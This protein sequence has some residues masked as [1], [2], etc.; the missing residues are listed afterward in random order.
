MTS[1]TT[2]GARFAGAAVPGAAAVLATGTAREPSCDAHAAAKKRAEITRAARTR[3]EYH[4][5]PMKRL[6]FALA[7]LACNKTDAS[8][9]TAEAAAP[10]ATKSAAPAA[11]FTGTLTGDRVMG[12]KG[13]VHPFDPWPDAQAKLEA[14]VGK[15][16]LVKNDKY[17]WAASQG[18]DCFYMQVEKQKDGTVG[19]VM[20]PMKVSKGGPI[21]NWDDCLTAAGVRKESAE[22]PNAPGPP[23][24]GKAVSVTDL[25]DGATKARSKWNGASVTVKGLYLNVTNLESNGVPMANV[26]ITAAKADLKNVISCSLADPKT[27][28]E[29]AHQYDPMT[30]QGTVKVRDMLTGGGD[31]VIDVDLEGCKVVSTKAK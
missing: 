22:D 11:P 14:Q 23:T 26:S 18:D 9:T 17:S 30:V 29:K 31:K 13:L 6:L 20:D 4:A 2:I 25:R 16:T 21:M 15:A 24:D 3:T 8:Q 5:D 1:A 19:M 10:A 27:A 28:P 12:A 7:L